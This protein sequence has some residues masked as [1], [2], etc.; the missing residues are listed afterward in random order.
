VHPQHDQGAIVKP[1]DDLRGPDR[2]IV[3][4]RVKVDPQSMFQE[5]LDH[6]V[7]EI[8]WQQ[9]PIP[10]ILCFPAEMPNSEANRSTAIGNV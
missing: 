4:D 1:L 2:Q 6:R 10:A 8:G 3:S 9:G 7:T 5:G